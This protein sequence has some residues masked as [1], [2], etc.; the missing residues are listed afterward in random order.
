MAHSLFGRPGNNPYC[1]YHVLKL[2]ER[3]LRERVER[4]EAASP[5]PFATGQFRL[6]RVSGQRCGQYPY[7][8]AGDV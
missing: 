7:G 8:D 1:H 2:R 5:L 4:V 6:N 3:G